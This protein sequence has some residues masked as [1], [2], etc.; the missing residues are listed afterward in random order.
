MTNPD[1][2]FPSEMPGGLNLYPSHDAAIDQVLNDLV[3]KC[4]AQFILLAE[5]NGQCLSVKG[6]RGKTDLVALGALIA[7]DLAAS[8]EIARLTDQYQHA[9]LIL[10]EGPRSTAFISEAGAQ[11]VLYMRVDKEV[12]MGWARLMVQEASN[13]LAQVISTRPEDVEKLDLSMSEEKLS[14]LI[15]DGLDSIWNG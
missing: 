12:P 3:Q 7:G 6:E 4:P 14:A 8:Q 10:R 1:F 9:Q 5:L 13:R 15:G 11:L 2:N